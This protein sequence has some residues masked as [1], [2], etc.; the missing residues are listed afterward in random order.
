MMIQRQTRGEIDVQDARERKQLARMLS[1]REWIVQAA[2]GFVGVVVV[3][4]LVSEF[5]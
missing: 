1:P 2:I 3:P 5:S 4:M